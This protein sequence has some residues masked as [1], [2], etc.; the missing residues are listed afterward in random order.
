M[1]EGIDTRVIEITARIFPEMDNT[2][3]IAEWA[4]ENPERVSEIVTA[5]FDLLEDINKLDTSD[6]LLQ[7]MVPHAVELK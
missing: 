5:Y 7:E 1:V 4:K 6:R 2:A 3:R